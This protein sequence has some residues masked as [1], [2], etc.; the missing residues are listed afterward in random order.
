MS[1]VQCII[2]NDFAIM[3]ADTRATKPNGEI[4]SGYNKMVKINNSIILGCTGGVFDNYLLFEQLCEYNKEKGLLKTNTDFSN[5]TYKDL[6]VVISKRLKNL[7]ELIIAGQKM[8]EIQCAICGYD[9]GVFKI[10][11][12]CANNPIKEMNGIHEGTKNSFDPFLGTSAGDP[13][14]LQLLNNKLAQKYIEMEKSKDYTLTVRQIKNM[15]LDIYDTGEKFD[16][17][18]NNDVK[19]EVIR[20]KDVM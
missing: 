6:M 14:H 20:K 15:L 3:A 5:L 13:R 8:L 17:T 16:N 4:V 9:E 18:I 2:T 10:A 11:S 7:N 19:F 12:V 1:L